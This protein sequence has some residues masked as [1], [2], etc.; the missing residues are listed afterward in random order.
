[1]KG[2]QVIFGTG[3]LGRSVMEALVGQG[4]QVRMVSRSGR[5]EDVPAGVEVLAADVYDLE[6]AK[7][8]ARGAGVV[9]NCAAPAYSGAAWETDLP[10]MWGNI[11][12]AAASGAKLVIGDNLYIYDQAPGPIREDRPLQATTRKGRARIRVVQAMLEAHAQGRVQVTLGR[13]ADFFGPYAT[14]QSHLGSRV[15]PALLEGKPVQMLHRLDIPHTFTY[16]ED[17]GK[18]LVTLGQREEALGQ[19]WHVP[20]AP[21]Q[22]PGEVLELAAKLAGQP[23]RIQSVQPWMLQALG[24]LVPVMREVGEMR[25]Q[26]QQPYQ[27]DSSK[28]EQTFGVRATPTDVALRRTLEFFRAQADSKPARRAA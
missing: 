27:V 23:L 12:E 2:F 21:T 20:N 26:F 5:M 28:F 16:I 25:Y 11:L 19:A 22:T 1:M 15:F 18:A 8:A 13:G 10:R 3:P 4:Q 17:F 14:Q 6:Q 9:Y 7:A 24:L